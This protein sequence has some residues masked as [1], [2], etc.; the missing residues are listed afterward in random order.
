MMYISERAGVNMAQRALSFHPAF[1]T[2]NMGFG[3][4]SNLIYNAPYQT[5]ATPVIAAVL[6]IVN[7]CLF[8][9]FLTMACARSIWF[10]R[11]LLIMLRH[12]AQCLFLG[13]F[14]M[15]M[16]TII[17]GTVYL[18][19]PRL[20]HSAGSWLPQF[21]AAL[22]WTDALLSLL[23]CVG[24]PL[25]MFNIHSLSLEEMNAA[26]LLPFVP[27]IVAAASGGVVATI[28]ASQ[29]AY[30]VLLVSWMLWGTSTCYIHFIPCTKMLLQ[31]LTA[32]WAWDYHY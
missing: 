11:S 32:A 10:P 2:V 5:R 28:L 14:P 24:I 4:V 22:W 27:P 6:Y 17:N 21:L 25:L 3:I 31:L 29:H 18:A 30:A 20:Q 13:T 15:G 1:W 19:M 9:I 23:A 12:P 26:W 7:I 8:T 16:A